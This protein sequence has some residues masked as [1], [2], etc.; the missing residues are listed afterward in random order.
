MPKSILIIDVDRNLRHSLA[1]ILQRSGYRVETA[2]GASEAITYLKT[3]KYDLVIIEM[4]MPDDGSILLQ[5]LLR[6]YPKLAFLVLTAQ[7]SPQSPM[8][9][10]HEGEHA[11]LVKPVTP[12]VLL[13]RVRTLL[14][15]P[16]WEAK[17]DLENRLSA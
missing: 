6:L 1:L 15:E 16:T 11:R 10:D 13:E 5:R 7:G 14:H 17:K 12:E 9:A 2:G 8:E 4:M 3:G